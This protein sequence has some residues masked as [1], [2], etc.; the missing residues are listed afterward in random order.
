MWLESTFSADQPTI[1]GELVVHEEGDSVKIQATDGFEV[2][3]VNRVRGMWFYRF[4]KMD[5]LFDMQ[6]VKFLIKLMPKCTIYITVLHSRVIML[7]KAKRGMIQDSW[8]C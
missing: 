7:L 4:L 2:K 8:R 5:Q 3:N 6:I 1:Y